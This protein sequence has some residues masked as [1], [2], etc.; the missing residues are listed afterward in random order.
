MHGWIAPQGEP[1]S[2]HRR[3]LEGDTF[4]EP[5]EVPV[6]AYGRVIATSRAAGASVTMRSSFRLGV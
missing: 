4:R 1:V 6:C 2:G 5:L 3:G